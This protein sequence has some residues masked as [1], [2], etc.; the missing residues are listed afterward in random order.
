MR[1]EK[2][3]INMIRDAKL[4][5]KFS[6]VLPSCPQMPSEY[7]YMS[8]YQQDLSDWS[9]PSWQWKLSKEEIQLEP[10]DEKPMEVES[11]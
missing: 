4:K 8:S 9:Q 10:S 1:I 2:K 5:F 6:P 3:K 11:C 7:Q